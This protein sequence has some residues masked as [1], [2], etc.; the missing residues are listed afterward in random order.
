MKSTFFERNNV[1]RAVVFSGG[2]AKGAFEIG[3]WK[4]LN[5]LGYYANIVTGTSIGALNG[6]LYLSG[7]QEEAEKLWKELEIKDVLNF[8]PP[9]NKGS[10]M[11]YGKTISEFMM[12]TIKEKG[13]SSTSLREIISKYIVDESNMRDKGIIFG[14]S[15]FNFKN[16]ETENIYL[17]DIHHGTL[18][19]YLLAS[20]ALF[21][22]MEKHYIN[23]IPY[24]DGGFGNNIPIDMALDKNPDQ[25]VIVD[26]KGPGVYKRDDRIK[27][28]EHIWVSTNWPLGDMLLFNQK[29]TELNIQLG[30]LEMMKRAMPKKYLGCWYTFHTENY[31]QEN[32]LFFIALNQVLTGEKTSQLYKQLDSK[33]YQKKLIIELSKKWKK[34]VDEKTVMLAIIEESGKTFN[35]SPD[36]QYEIKEFQNIILERMKQWVESEK[37]QTAESIY[38]L[39]IMN[40][41]DWQREFFEQLPLISN[42]RIAIHIFKWLNEGVLTYE[43]PLFYM[44]LKVKPYSLMIALYC[45]YLLSKES[46]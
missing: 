6:A 22:I 1:R 41:Q 7:K 15:V 16:M 8:K 42:R 13:L 5:A 36:K 19:D 2:G 10:I 33:S 35:V 4:A 14:L 45:N 46:G 30:Y 17:D 9:E 32:D 38:S 21:P 25:M 23:D 3:V 28:C 29:R 20:S 24:I 37:N 40:G 43:E 31:Q 27:N 44:F 18:I 39:N 34:S 12:Y 26:I 11:Y